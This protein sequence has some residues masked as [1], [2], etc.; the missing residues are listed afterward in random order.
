M[1]KHKLNDRYGSLVNISPYSSKHGGKWKHLMLC[2]CG[3]K[4]EVR[5]SSLSR[6]DTTSCGCLLANMSTTHGL[7]NSP[8]YPVWASMKQR[9]L[10]EN[11]IGYKN[12]GG[13]GITFSESWNSFESFIEDMGS[14]P[15]PQASLERI[16]N[17]K[18]YSKDNCKW[19]SRHQQS[20]NQRIR[21]DNKT[22]HRGVCFRPV[23]KKYYSQIS[24]N[25]KKIHLGCFLN[26]EDAI[27]ARLEA[28]KTYYNLGE[29]H[30]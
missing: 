14:K 20:V 24:I 29:T 18:G 12:Y 4:K 17:D 30:E 1:R 13:R 19:A 28:E 11:Y 26:I 23:Q 25:G 9:C 21:S 22:G 3:N 15:Y 2:D 16:D 6:G 7:S 27:K 10:N 5:G 8:E